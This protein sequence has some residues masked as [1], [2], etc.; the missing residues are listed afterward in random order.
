M[1]KPQHYLTGG[2]RNVIVIGKT[3]SGKSTLANQITCAGEEETF[4]VSRS[5]Q[6]MTTEVKAVIEHIQIGTKRYAIHMID[7]AG[8]RDAKSGSSGMS[9]ASIINDIKKYMRE[10]TP[11]GINVIIFVYKNG[12]FSP[13]EKAV[14]QIITN[15]F[16]NYI[17]KL[18]CLVIT[19]CD[20]LNDEARGKLVSEFKTSEMTREYAALMGKGIYTVGFP[21]LSDLSGRVR[22]AVAADMQ[23]DINP[24]LNMIAESK[25]L[26]LHEEIQKDSFWSLCAIL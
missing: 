8:F 14:F 4:P 3:G 18:S 16:K 17:K 9:D 24:I 10:S 25:E 6:S 5:Y 26:H 21:R 20:G 12:R 2:H 1:A 19:N 22:E 7:T 15:H 11:E 13:E 23:E